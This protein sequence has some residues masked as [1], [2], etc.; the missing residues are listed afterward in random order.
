MAD[1]QHHSFKVRR[2]LILPG[3][4]EV[5]EKAKRDNID[6]GKLIAAVLSLLKKY[7]AVRK[8]AYKLARESEVSRA[9]RRLNEE[10]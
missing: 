2:S 6:Y 1:K 8:E 7:P 9:C 4:L 5:L 3:G 10:K